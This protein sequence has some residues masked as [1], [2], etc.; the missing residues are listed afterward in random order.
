MAHEINNPLEGVTNLLYLA[1]RSEDFQEARKYLADADIELQRVSAITNQT[2]KFHKQST[3]PTEMDAHAMIDS[4][5]AIYN[6]R[7][8]NSRIK[9]QKLIRCARS[10]LCF[11]SEIR[12]VLSN[13]ISNAIDAMHSEGGRLFVRCHERRDWQS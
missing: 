10:V 6:S 4:V 9:L 11:E 8:T 1:E 12:Q 3:K 2:L 7:L 5:L 13:V